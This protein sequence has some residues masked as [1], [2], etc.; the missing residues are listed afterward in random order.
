MNTGNWQFVKHKMN[1]QFQESRQM[2]QPHSGP[3]SQ[4][5]KPLIMTSKGSNSDCSNIKIKGN[6]YI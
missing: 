6:N 3:L 2:A 1:N 5:L 4:S